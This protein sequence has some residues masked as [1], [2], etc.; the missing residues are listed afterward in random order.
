MKPAIFAAALAA[1]AIGLPLA[2]WP[3]VGQT[4]RISPLIERRCASARLPLGA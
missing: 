4:A 1:L 2:S 3:A